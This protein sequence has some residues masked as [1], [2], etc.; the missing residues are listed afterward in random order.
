MIPILLALPTILPIAEKIFGAITNDQK[1]SIIGK[2]AGAVFS[3]GVESSISSVFRDVLGVMDDEKRLQFELE[4]QSLL[5]QLNLNA[6]EEQS[7]SA[8]QRGWRPTLAWLGVIGIAIN[9]IGLFLFHTILF[10]LAFTSVDQDTL[11]FAYKMVPS[12]DLTLL[13]TLLVQMLGVGTQAVLRTFEKYNDLHN[14][15]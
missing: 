10:V 3:P 14:V 12:V 2:L 5:G 15:H 9:T 13:G 6:L 1:T 4:L 8:F 7:D 11:D